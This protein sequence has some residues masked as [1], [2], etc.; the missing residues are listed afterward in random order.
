[1]KFREK[2]KQTLGNAKYAIQ[3]VYG[4][5]KKYYLYH[6][7]IALADTLQT[8]FSVIFPAAVIGYLYPALQLEKAVVC[9]SLW[10]FLQLALSLARNIFWKKVSLAYV[11]IFIDIKLKM[12]NW[13]SQIRYEELEQANSQDALAFATKCIERGSV[14]AI[15]VETFSIIGA[16]VSLCS[17]TGVMSRVSVFFLLLALLVLLTDSVSESRMGKILLEKQK[18]LVPAQ[19][20]ADY[21]IW[22]LT[23]AENGKE[24]RLYGMMEYMTQKFRKASGLILKIGE[25]YT[26]PQAKLKLVPS[27]FAG[28]QH[29]MIY[30]WTVYCLWKGDISVSE[31]TL[32]TAAILQFSGLIS[33]IGKNIIYISYENQYIENYRLFAMRESGQGDKEQEEIIDTAEEGPSIEYR[34]VW[35]RYPGREEYAL[36]DVNIKILPNTR[37]SIVG[38]NGSGKSTF[39]KLMAGFYRPTKGEILV[40]G[41]DLE[42][43]TQEQRSRIF[44]PVFQ[45]YFMTDYSVR[46]N[47]TL[48]AGEPETGRI[49]RALEEAGVRDVVEAMPGG[50]ECSLTRKLDREGSELSG[51]E[52][53][54][55]AIAR[56]LY[57]DAPVLILDEPTA[58]LSPNAEYEIYRNLDQMS[59]GRTVLFISHRLASC[60]FCGRILVF[61]KGEICEEGSHEELMEKGGLYQSMFMT[62]AQYYD[63]QEKAARK[64]GQG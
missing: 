51:G 37:V 40:N 27:L 54:K 4:I 6:T 60:R 59:S 52:K 2:R 38:M 63:E 16:F 24:Q 43:M 5:D 46:E 11:C 13:V 55:L 21:T 58:A 14:T 23:D 9:A 34:H 61:D 31:F 49:Y 18:E 64:G 44:A 19:R 7:M 10:G 20:K 29:F 15:V 12:E 57:K 17:L 33:S 47:V 53:Q 39:I 1:M 26:W 48:S 28:V 41:I 36:R 8:V 42:E 25:G 3:M 50:M 35:Y 45:D 62:Q 56:A 30:G 22:R 32:F